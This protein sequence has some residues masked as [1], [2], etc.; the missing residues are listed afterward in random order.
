MSKEGRR[1]RRI[2]GLDGHDAA[3]SSIPPIA[4]GAWVRPTASCAAFAIDAADRDA[5]SMGC[6]IA[7]CPRR[8]STARWTWRSSPCCCPSWHLLASVEGINAVYLRCA[9]HLGLFGR[10][11]RAADGDRGFGD[12]I[13]PRRTTRSLPAPGTAFAPRIRPVPPPR[14]HY[15]PSSAAPG[16]A[17]RIESL[18][19]IS[20][21]TECMTLG[22][23]RSVRLHDFAQL[24]GAS[25]VRDAVARL[26][27]RA[28][29]P[30][31]WRRSGSWLT[32]RDAGRAS[33]FDGDVRSP[34][35][36]DRSML[37]GSTPDA[38][39]L[40]PTSRRCSWISARPA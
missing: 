13:D 28:M 21:C 16:L 6:R 27:R 24:D 38:P 12:L 30:E 4:F 36:H 3:A 34:P 14:R 11:R 10:V 40:N 19:A 29:L 7:S 35:P 31:C 9:S 39:Y 22:E 37:T 32:R 5:E 23:D 33:S 18:V 15:L 20:S 8:V 25:S 1:G 26:A 17:R 2:G